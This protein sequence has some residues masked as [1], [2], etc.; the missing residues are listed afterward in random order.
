MRRIDSEK[1]TVEFMIRLYCRNNH[2]TT[3]GL[4]RGCERLKVYAFERLVKC[5]F[6]GAKTA[7]KS[8]SVH[9]YTAEMRAKIREIMRYSGTRMIIYY[10]IDF[11]RH[12]LKKKPLKQ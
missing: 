2:G 7:C 4:C 11:I 1:H 9:C 8:C 12:L 5:P 10:P 6:G 3:Q